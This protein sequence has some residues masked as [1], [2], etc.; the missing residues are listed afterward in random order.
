MSSMSVA[1]P[2]AQRPQSLVAAVVLTLVV[3]IVGNIIAFFWLDAEE[4]RSVVGGA[5]GAFSIGIHLL[6][7]WGL[8]NLRRW[9]WILALVLTVLEIVS[10]IPFFG[11]DRSWFVAFAA[12]AV[13]V[14]VVILALLLVPTTRAV[15]RKA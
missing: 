12:I 2:R 8:W 15:F 7:L 13:V 6:S 14:E 3:T 1:Q 5:I 10:S 4:G 9:G 11:D